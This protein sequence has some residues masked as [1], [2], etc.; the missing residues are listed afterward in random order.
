MWVRGV[1]GVVL[2]VVGAVWIAQ[3]TGAMKGSFMS[4]HAEY[5][6][7]GVV[8]A[9]IGVALIIWA[10]RVRRDERQVTG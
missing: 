1:I 8:T 9:V 4:G 2:L 3:G 6:A 7:L 5:T 10:A